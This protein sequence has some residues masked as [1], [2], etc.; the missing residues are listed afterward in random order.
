MTDKNNSPLTKIRRHDRAKDDAWV[1]KF[2][3]SGEIGTMATSVDGQPFLVTRNFVFDEAAHSIY[4]HGARKGRTSDNI[5]VNDKVCFSVQEPGRLLP[6]DEALEFGTEF[7]GV[8]IFGRVALVTDETE[9]THGLKLLM[10]K[11]APHLEYGVDYAPVDAAGLKITAV[12]RIDIE[13]WSGKAKQ[14]EAD[15]PGAFYYKDVAV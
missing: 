4:M 2:L 3:T 9:A 10:T 7:A 13:S 15:F 11:Y 14:V 1:R 12:L 6:A 5:Q 8:I